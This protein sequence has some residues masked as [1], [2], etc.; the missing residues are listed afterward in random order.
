[1]CRTRSTVP[2]ETPASSAISFTVMA[3]LYPGRA[4][5]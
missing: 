1:L 3:L 4:R 2:M 5:G